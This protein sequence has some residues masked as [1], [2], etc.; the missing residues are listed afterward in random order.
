M[1]KP[2]GDPEGTTIEVNLPLSKIISYNVPTVGVGF[3]FFIASL[4]LMKFATDELLI[5]PAA[6][7]VIFGLS[8]IWD[9]VTDP[10]AGYFSDRTTL[11]SGRRRPWILASIIPICLTFYMIW[12]PPSSLSEFGNIIWMGVAVILFYTAMTA[13]SVP[14]TALGAELSNN[15]HERTKIFGL[16][17]MIWGWRFPAGAYGHGP[18]NPG[19]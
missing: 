1:S 15:Y 7:G 12:N 2:S 5:P 14:H 17:H 3:M 19:E 16:R 8:R 13:F 9:A 4:Y 18:V 11:K 6:M 10:L